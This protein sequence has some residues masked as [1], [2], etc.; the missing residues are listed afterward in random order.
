MKNYIIPCSWKDSKWLTETESKS[1]F[2]K[3]RKYQGST[4]ITLWNF[5]FG[6]RVFFVRAPAKNMW[7]PLP[8]WAMAGNSWEFLFPVSVYT[9][10][11]NSTPICTTSD[12]ALWVSS[13]KP[14]LYP[15]DRSGMQVQNR[16]IKWLLV[17]TQRTQLK[18]LCPK[19]KRP[20]GRLVW[21]SPNLLWNQTMNSHK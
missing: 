5:C 4:S 7:E 16:L 2:Q 11:W 3:N 15:L 20:K 18:W 19:E 6:S 12:T 9:P 14:R 10:W 21:F 17:A 1:I 13:K 8:E